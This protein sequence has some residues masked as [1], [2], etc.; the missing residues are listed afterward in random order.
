MTDN[1]K[2]LITATFQEYYD[3]AREV[4]N[5]LELWDRSENLRGRK[6]DV[7]IMLMNLDNKLVEPEI[8]KTEKVEEKEEKP[9]TKK[10]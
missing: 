3:L 1:K 8:D 6:L 2:E 7:A 9:T 5:S 10:K 4:I